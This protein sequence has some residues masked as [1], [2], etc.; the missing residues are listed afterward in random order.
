[1]GT[2]QSANRAR[3][4]PQMG[5]P[6]ERALQQRPI[7]AIRCAVVQRALVLNRA[8]V[9]V[10]CREN[11]VGRLA[12][13]GEIRAHRVQ[14][15]FDLVRMDAPHPQERELVSCPRGVCADQSGVAQFGRDIVRRHHAVGQRGRRDLAFRAAYQ[16]MVELAG[17]LHGG[18]A[19]RP[20][21]GTD[22]VHQP[23]IEGFDAV[24]C[25]D[26]P[27]FMECAVRLDQHMHRYRAFDAAAVFD[28][29]QGS[30]LGAHVARAARLWQ[31]HEGQARTGPGNQDL[32]IGSPVVMGDVVDAHADPVVPVVTA[33]HDL[34]AHL[35]VC[36]LGAGSGSILAITGDVEHR[37]QF[38]LQRERLADQFLGAC[39]V[40]DRGQGRELALAREEHP[41]RVGGG[42]V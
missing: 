30:E 32:Q 6:V 25:R 42:L 5:T 41:G 4:D 35:G 31:G 21:V 27:D 14:D 3:T 7:V 26:L 37:P 34:R 13:F 33:H 29:A 20:A 36:L 23:K 8:P 22:E 18:T 1:M 2:V 24:D 28:L 17:T 40:V 16:R 19:D 10:D 39:V 12:D 9:G 11:D 15:R 38:G